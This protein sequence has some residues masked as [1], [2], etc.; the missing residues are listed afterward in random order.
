MS[1]PQA[2]KQRHAWPAL[3][4]SLA[5]LSAAIVLQACDRKDD[6]FPPAPTYRTGPAP[7]DLKGPRWVVDPY[8]PG[9]DLPPVGQSLFDFLVTEKVGQAAAYR[10]PFPLPALLTTIAKRL[11]D[12]PQS[13]PSVKSVLIPLNRSLQR[14]AAKPDF[15]K[16]PRAV[17]AVDT[18]PP[19]R[20]GEA[21]VL[22]KDRLFLGYHEKANVIEVISYNEAAGRFEFQV[23]KDY[24]AGG[25]PQVLY[26][27]RALCTV[28]HQNQA[29]IFSRPLWDE[30]NA[31]PKIAALLRAQS[32]DFYG[33]PV[34]QGVDIP[35]ALDEATDRAN[36]L[37]AYQLLWREGCAGDPMPSEPIACRANLFRFALRYL[38]TG[39]RYSDSRS[40]QDRTEPVQSLLRHWQDQWPHG[41]RIP[42]PDIPNRNPFL[43]LAQLSRGPL[44][45]Q[46]AHAVTRFVEELADRTDIRSTFEPSV[47]REPREIWP[48]SQQWLDALDRVIVGLAGFLA[49]ADA[50]RLDAHLVAMAAQDTS[51]GQRYQRPCDF[52]IRR[53]ASAIERLSFRCEQP[54]GL[55]RG[56]GDSF[57]MEGRIYLENGTVARGAID[58]L[59]L[60]GHT[61][62]NLEVINGGL[63]PQGNEWRATLAVRQPR[64]GL[65]ARRADGQA[66][67]RITLEWKASSPGAP[68]RA[69][70]GNATLTVLDDF[71]RVDAA[72]DELVRL[73]RLGVLDVFSAK[74]FRRAALMP[75][76]YEQLGLAPL[77]WCCIDARGMPR[78]AVVAGANGSHEH[79]RDA[80]EIPAIKSFRQHCLACHQ[81]LDS[82][83]P[84]FLSGSS[85][86]IQ[87]NLRHCAERIF[88]RLEMWRLSP[89]ER[90]E[91]PMP[92]INAFRRHIV[93]P[94]HSPTQDHLEILKNYVADVLK[95][96]TGKAPRLEDFTTRG[97]DHLRDCLPVRG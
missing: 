78:P 54:D 11:G 82:F 65:H 1:V 33:L 90:P 77:R 55:G 42:D 57:A 61:L 41:L 91:T 2:C 21:G 36:E 50:R 5:L 39:T 68:D 95:S 73:T 16:Y 62:S 72:I 89:P 24:R 45:G 28:C 83:P 25:T 60:A 20:P 80:V 46:F 75:A 51:R 44:A 3:I 32:R 81:G 74:P 19:L 84:N 6:D 52:A 58:R 9:A 15:F 47:P 38:L 69:I 40:R 67:G 22:L 27:N 70:P 17:A 66:I 53:R 79:H 30:T 43:H 88:F 93:S 34:E 92:P 18:E 14:H 94:G 96:Q 64:T 85:D 49:T 37:A 87:E 26:A 13:V 31:N 4:W 76:L 59:L 8:E 48:A 56:S 86:R 71:R 10:V 23:V 29:P 7:S 63:A 35:N 12:E 97:Y